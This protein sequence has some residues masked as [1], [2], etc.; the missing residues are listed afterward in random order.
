MLSLARAVYL[1]RRIMIL[2]EATAYLDAKTEKVFQKILDQ[3]F[4]QTTMII[5]THKI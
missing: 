4:G 2:D 1:K 5:V 3:Q